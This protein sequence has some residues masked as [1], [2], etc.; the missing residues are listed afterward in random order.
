MMLW[1]DVGGSQGGTQGKQVAL[2]G[3]RGLQ[4]TCWGG[5]GG[6]KGL[7]QASWESKGPCGAT[8]AEERSVWRIVG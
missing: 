8:G 3:A 1:E 2:S 5:F 6:S 7:C 4:R